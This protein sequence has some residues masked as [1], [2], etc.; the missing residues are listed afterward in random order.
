MQR[1]VW[2]AWRDN[3]GIVYAPR[4]RCIELVNQGLLSESATLLHEIV[5]AT[6]EEA[7]TLHY[8]KMGFGIYKPVGRQ[9]PCPNKCGESYYPDGYGD[10]P[11]CGHI[12]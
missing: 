12:G 3:D 8:E 9:T 1:V 10:C 6:G 2:Q 11:N 5:A 4:E 7:M